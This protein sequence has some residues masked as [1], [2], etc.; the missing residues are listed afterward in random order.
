MEAWPVKAAGVLL[1][2]GLLT[3]LLAPSQ[4]EVPK[5]MGEY[6]VL[7]GDFHI[8][9]FP[10]D[11]STLAP[12]DVVVEA[13]RR[14]LDVIA[15][16]GHNH[17]WTAQI[18]RWFSQVTGGPL[19]LVGEEIITPPYDMVAVGLQNTVDW[20]GTAAEQ[21]AAIHRQGGVAIAAHPLR[22]AW[23]S[24]D[25][26]A[27]RELDGAEVLHPMAFVGAQFAAELREFYERKTLTAIG[28]SDFHG[29]SFPGFSRTY[30]F[31][32]EVTERAVVEALR[33]RQTI[34]VDRDG[35][36][37][38]DP[39]LIRIA[40]ANGGLPP[41]GVVPQFSVWSSLSRIA[42]LAGMLVGFLWGF[43]ERS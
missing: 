31:V 35:H 16:T 25:E 9:M 42:A 21:I 13:R 15:L 5:T 32:H 33:H 24:Y 14:G 37:Y 30:V 43:N 23:P 28:S 1:L 40:A 39:E 6:H 27:M 41:S 36:S 3:G 22:V 8:H 29:T 20:R 19:V 4:S 34:A 2:V 26:A 10:L 38:G 18:G 17:T 12:W 7:T 11:A